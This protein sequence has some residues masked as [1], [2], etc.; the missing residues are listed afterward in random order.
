MTDPCQKSPPDFWLCP[1]VWIPAYI[2]YVRGSPTLVC[3]AVLLAT[4]EFYR[5]SVVTDSRSSGS[6]PC[7]GT[8]PIGHTVVG[9]RRHISKPASHRCRSETSLRHPL[10]FSTE[11]GC[12]HWRARGRVGSTAAPHRS[13][14]SLLM[15][16]HP[17]G[18]FV[19]GPPRRRRIKRQLAPPPL[20]W[21]LAFPAIVDGP[22]YWRLPI[23]L[24]ESTGINYPHLLLPGCRSIH[25]QVQTWCFAWD[26]I[27]TAQQCFFFFFLQTVEVLQLSSPVFWA[28]PSDSWWAFWVS[29]I[30]AYRLG[31]FKSAVTTPLFRSAGNSPR[32]NEVLTKTVRKGANTLWYSHR[33]QE[34]PLIHT[35]VR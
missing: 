19:D 1:L 12:R 20:L 31:F 35:G 34:G 17:D 3:W 21:L 30:E 8:K 9:R 27:P 26:G 18:L 16:T 11:V 4:T 5:H 6:T 24:T 28:S 32:A 14:P 2:L 15:K 10:R 23:S 25:T 29:G 13:L 7:L 22:L 33:N